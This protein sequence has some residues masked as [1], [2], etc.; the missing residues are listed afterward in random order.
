MPRPWVSPDI[1]YIT[2]CPDFPSRPT[3][4]TLVRARPAEHFDAPLPAARDLQVLQRSLQTEN[5]S[6]ETLLGSGDIFMLD[7]DAK[8]S[9]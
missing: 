3:D 1:H 8:M 2:L 4:N 7:A 6:S 9:T 5:V